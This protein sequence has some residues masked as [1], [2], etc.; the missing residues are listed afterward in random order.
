MSVPDSNTSETPDYNPDIQPQDLDRRMQH[1]SNVMNHFG[2]DGEKN[3]SWNCETLIVMLPPRGTL[4][5]L[6]PLEK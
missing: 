2:K 4:I 5:E 3:I 6:C 1:L